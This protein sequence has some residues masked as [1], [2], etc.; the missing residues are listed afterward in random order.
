MSKYILVLSTKV[1]DIYILIYVYKYIN[2]YKCI[3]V[4]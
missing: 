4:Y 2:I 1:F 3:N